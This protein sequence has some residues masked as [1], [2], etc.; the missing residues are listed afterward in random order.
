MAKRQLKL[1]IPTGT[2][3]QPLVYDICREFRLVAHIHRVS[4]QEN[5]GVVILGL[6]GDDADIDKA[7]VWVS[8]K[9]IE[10]EPLE[11]EVAQS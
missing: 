9:G 4:I 11:M 8:E 5:K 3:T 6:E 10:V 2:I 1:V 7:L